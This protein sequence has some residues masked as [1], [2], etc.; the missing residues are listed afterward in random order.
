ML[1]W[2]YYN[3]SIHKPIGTERFNAPACMLE[4]DMLSK[5]RKSYAASQWENEGGAMMPS[6]IEADV[7][8][9][10]AAYGITAIPH[11]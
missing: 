11:E 10:L 1:L 6:T 3:H 7:G 8:L 9:K 5:S 2:V 4:L